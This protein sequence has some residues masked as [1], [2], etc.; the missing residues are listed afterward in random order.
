ML[1]GTIQLPLPSCYRYRRQGDPISDQRRPCPCVGT[2]KDE[3]EC[4]SKRVASAETPLR[5]Y[6]NE[7]A[8]DENG[9]S[10][11][12]Q[13][14]QASVNRFFVWETEA[15]SWFLSEV[16][17]EVKERGKEKT[18]EEGAGDESELEYQKRGRKSICFDV[19]CSKYTYLWRT[20]S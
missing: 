2:F 16:A 19:G 4:P 3:E 13:S 8:A 7:T 20:I 5:P 12:S 10:V 17:G 6:T 9:A 18:C 11:E 14:K 1:P 15:M